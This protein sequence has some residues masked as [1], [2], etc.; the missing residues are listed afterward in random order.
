MALILNPDTGPSFVQTAAL[1][2]GS[3]LQ[4][5]S[6]QITTP[7]TIAPGTG[8]ITLITLNFTPKSASSKLYVRYF[9]AQTTK[10]SG[11]GTNSWFN[12]SVLVDGVGP[13][14]DSINT[15]CG[16]VGYPEG[17]SDQR[18]TFTGE[19]VMNSW[20]KTQKTFTHIG[21]VG[22]SGSNWTVSHQSYPTRLFV[23]EIQ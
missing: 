19:F 3:L 9:H 20:G 14:D 12:A 22:S 8:A 5:A 11:A 16:A 23:F 1:P 10:V 6:A 21:V 13:E 2:T 4:L 7:V 15:G 18:Y 17:A